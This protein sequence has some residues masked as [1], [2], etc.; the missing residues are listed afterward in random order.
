[1]A[2]FAEMRTRELERLGQWAEGCMVQTSGKVYD[3]RRAIV[4]EGAVSD[5]GSG[6]KH[7]AQEHYAVERRIW[8]G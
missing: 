6:A 4:C 2:I 1:M 8:Q 3:C 5:D 7:E